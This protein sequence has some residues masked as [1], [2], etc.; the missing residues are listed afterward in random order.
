MV[1]IALERHPRLFL[2]EKPVHESVLEH[3]IMC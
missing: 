3:D 1:T 2:A